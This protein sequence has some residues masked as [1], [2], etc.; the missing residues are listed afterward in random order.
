MVHAVEITAPFPN[1]PRVVYG[2]NPL[3]EVICQVRF[4]TILRISSEPP[5]EFQEQVRSEYPVLNVNN[6]TANIQV[7]QGVP[8]AIAT[9][10]KD[11][12]P[13]RKLGGYDFVSADGKWKV[14]LTRDFLSLSTQEYRNW[15]EFRAHL[16]NPLKALVAVYAPAFFTRIGL[17]YQDLIQ[18][19]KLGLA[20]S[21]PWSQLLRPPISGILS[22]QIVS[23]SVEECVSQTV[24]RLPQFNSKVHVNYGIARTVD[25]NE[26]CFLIDSDFYSEE[27]TE[28][29]AVDGILNYFNRQSGRL[30]RWCIEDRLHTAMQPHP[31]GATV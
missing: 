4:P 3:I 13:N 15:Q 8:P 26:E 28:Q 16:G 2:Q 31:V 5:V 21:T 24:I 30:F 7:P 25:K 1:S 6:T 10:L 19:S 22:E 29:N 20:D 23:D 18:K 17:R 27:R 14:T 12:I 9:L 11:L